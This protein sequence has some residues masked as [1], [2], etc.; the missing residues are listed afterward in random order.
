MQLG[1]AAKGRRSMDIRVHVEGQYYPLPPEVQIALYRIAQESLNNIIKHSQASEVVLNLKL[2]AALVELD[3]QD[4][5]Q[6]FDQQTKTGGLG[7][8]TMRE[9]AEQIGASFVLT[10]QVGRGTV[11]RVVW[12]ST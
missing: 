11:A 6:G 8:N 3:I 5:G 10:S 1:E 7:L 9:R 4:N 2:E 12:C